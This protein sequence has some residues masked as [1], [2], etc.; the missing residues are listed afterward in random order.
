M[1][2]CQADDVDGVMRV[3]FDDGQRGVLAY[4]HF[5]GRVGG[6]SRRGAPLSYIY[7]FR[8]VYYQKRG[9]LGPEQSFSE[10][11][12]DHHLMVGKWESLGEDDGA[13]ALMEDLDECLRGES[14]G[15]DI[16]ALDGAS[17]RERCF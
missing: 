13:I 15:D 12:S 2:R 10:I 6:R 1:K 7:K 11:R 5:V 3:G 14:K 8:C 16:W 17:S 4:G 9:S